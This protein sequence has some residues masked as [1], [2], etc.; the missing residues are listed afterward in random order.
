LA[1][2]IEVTAEEAKRVVEIMMNADG[3][4]SYCARDLIR[5]FV[6]SFG[7]ADIATAVFGE[8]RGYNWDEVD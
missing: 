3:G 2:W 8:E 7:H 4:C 5:Q 6:A 1:G